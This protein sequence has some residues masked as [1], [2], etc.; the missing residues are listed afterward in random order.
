MNDHENL[1]ENVDSGQKINDQEQP[2][3][4]P[5]RHQTEYPPQEAWSPPP[6]IENQNYTENNT[7][8][9]FGQSC[10]LVCLIVFAIIGFAVVGC[11][12]VLFANF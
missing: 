12:I 4:D 6:G 5:N 11:F 1:D 9:S 10:L 8:R 2:P 3:F 7:G